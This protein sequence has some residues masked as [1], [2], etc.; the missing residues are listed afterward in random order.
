MS[1][2]LFTKFPSTYDDDDDDDNVYDDDKR[3][4]IY[5]I[6]IMCTGLIF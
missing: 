5:T 3:T 6:F 2:L 1:T 4:I